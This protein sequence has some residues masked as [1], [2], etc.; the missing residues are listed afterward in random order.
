MAT[1]NSHRSGIL[2]FDERLRTAD[3]R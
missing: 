1:A 3:R 2:T